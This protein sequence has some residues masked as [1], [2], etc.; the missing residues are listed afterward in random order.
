MCWQSEVIICT[1]TSLQIPEKNL[2]GKHC[3][4]TKFSC[5]DL[6]SMSSSG[7]CN[8]VVALFMRLIIPAARRVE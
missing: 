3:C 8:I 1:K 5:Q 6:K 7:G 4:E 2:F